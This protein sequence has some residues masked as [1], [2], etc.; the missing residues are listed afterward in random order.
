MLTIAIAMSKGGVAKTTSVLNLSAA[1][2]RS[3]RRVLMI[4]LDGQGNLSSTYNLKDHDKNVYKFLVEDTNMPVL[5]VSDNL[6]LMPGAD[7]M[8]TFD[9]K[10]KEEY[11]SEAGFLLRD[12]LSAYDLESLYDII[13]IDCPP[14]IDM[15]TIAALCAADWLFIPAT[16]DQWAIDGIARTI[17]VA[18]RVA[19]SSNTNLKIGGIFLTRY[20]DRAILYKTYRDRLRK[21]YAS[22]MLEYFTRNNVTLSEAITEGS[23]VFT[24]DQRKK[25]KSNGSVDYTNLAKEILFITGIENEVEKLNIK[26]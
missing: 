22:W 16:P 13:M 19:S 11:G 4:D 5:K 25:Q 15:N 9:A 2:A 14:K 7:L 17:D 6:F 24:Y 18:N 3:G 23:D 12:R 21:A 20:D 10:S 26:A 8:H 1:F